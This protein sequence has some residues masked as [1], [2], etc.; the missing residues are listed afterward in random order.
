MV[1]AEW[2][3]STI[4]R[5]RERLQE[6]LGPE[7]LSLPQSGLWWA[8]A[9]TA[10]APETLHNRLKRKTFKNKTKAR[11]KQSLKRGQTLQWEAQTHTAG[12]L[13]PRCRNHPKPHPGSCMSPQHQ[14]DTGESKAVLGLSKR[15]SEPAELTGHEHEICSLVPWI[16]ARKEIFQEPKV[17]LRCLSCDQLIWAAN[18]WQ[19]TPRFP[20]AVNLW[21][22]PQNHHHSEPK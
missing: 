16:T 21:C 2:S 8:P 1:A 3:N 5:E 13:S 12:R 15:S 17:T 14:G 7:S 10:E 20:L 18:H 6:V 9:H 19:R 11:T 22:F 4:C